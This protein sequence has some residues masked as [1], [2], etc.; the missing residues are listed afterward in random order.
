M[1][2]KSMIEGQPWK[3]IIR[4]AF[5]VLLGSLLQQLYNTVDTII[6]GRFASEEALSAVGTTGTLTFFF[7]A[8]AIGFSAGNGVVIAQ[9][10]GAGNEKGVRKNAS[11]GIAFLMILGVVSAILGIVLAKPAFKYVMSVP[12]EILSLTI[13]YFMI[14][15]AGLIFQYGYNAL[16][17]ILRAVGDS[18]ATLYFLLISSVANVIL[19]L[20]F[21]AVFRWGVV[22]AALATDISQLGSLIAAFIYMR[23]K[24]PV[25]VF[26]MSEYKLD[27]EAIKKTVQIG[28]PISLQLVIV[29]VGLTFIQRAVNEFGKIMTA[30]FT[31]GNRIE[32]YI[33]LPFNALQ[34]TLATYTGQNIGANRLDRVKKGVK[35]TIIISLATTV[36]ISSLIWTFAGSIAGI[37]GLSEAALVYCLPH[38][39]TVAVVNIILSMYVPLFGL[40]QGMGHSGSPTIVAT[41]ALG[42]RVFVTY[43]LRNSPFL[44]YQIIWW[45]G[46]FGFSV[47]FTITWFFYFS[48]KWQKR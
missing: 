40:Y 38:I 30:S 23:S 36:V 6:V 14:Y 28:M 24:Y 26:K 5:P 8:I 41:C 48:N 29:S 11:T 25:F 43:L 9:C 19:D 17:S 31:V 21:V 7:L 20:L 44:G 47:G 12:E 3:H 42:V 1:N 27:P 18:S 15:A 37:F 16:S 33:N 39:K 22:G 32:Q 13:Q 10:Y 4:F 46:L 34:T 35:Q 45:N 2:G